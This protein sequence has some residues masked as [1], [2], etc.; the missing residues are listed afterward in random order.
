M[1]ILII[2]LVPARLLSLSKSH[3]RSYP[4]PGNLSRGCDS[5]KKVVFWLFSKISLFLL[6]FCPSAHFSLQALLSFLFYAKFPLYV[7]RSSISLLLVETF[8]KMFDLSVD[9]FFLFLFRLKAWF[10]VLYV[11]SADSDNTLK[12]FGFHTFFLKKLSFYAWPFP[13]NLSYS[14]IK[15]FFLCNLFYFVTP[16]AAL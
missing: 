16:K 6:S 8:Q 5:E 14:C 7:A 3:F 9:G 2:V 1:R 10:L 15:F 13:F 4:P 12:L 11:S